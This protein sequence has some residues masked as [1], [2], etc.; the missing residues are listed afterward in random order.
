[1]N[2]NFCATGNYSRSVP[3]FG[4]SIGRKAGDSRFSDGS[5]GGASVAAAAATGSGGESLLRM[6]GA[7]S[8]WIDILRL[9]EQPAGH[10]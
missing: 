8:F 4:C 3:T 6:G 10:S 9:L 7:E 1:M 2:L 5:V